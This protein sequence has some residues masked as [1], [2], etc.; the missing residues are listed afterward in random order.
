MA[1]IS[2]ELT[3][4]VDELHQVLRTG[5]FR[6]HFVTLEAEAWDVASAPDSWYNRINQRLTCLGSTLAHVVCMKD[7]SAMF[8]ESIHRTHVLKR[9]LA[10]RP[11]VAHSRDYVRKDQ[12]WL[13]FAAIQL[14][15][16]LFIAE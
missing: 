5:E 15:Y 8:T 14:G 3:A 9:I 11:A 1:A 16:T 6:G 4:I 13:C 10:L 12:L 7:T 2:S